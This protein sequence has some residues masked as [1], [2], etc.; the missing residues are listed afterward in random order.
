MI[1][2]QN[3]DKVK[4]NLDKFDK[5]REELIKTSREIVRESKKIIYSIHRNEKVSTTKI[6]TSLKS[7]T[8]LAKKNPKLLYSGSV[9]I[10][11]QEYVEA[12]AFLEFNKSGKIIPYNPEFIDDEFY[13]LG[14]CDL[15]GE[16]VRKAVQEGINNKN[17]AVLNIRKAVDELYYKIL[18][19]DLRN[20]ELRKKSDG[21]KW[22]LKK[23]DE[24]VF[25]LKLR[26]P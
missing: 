21:I 12:I 9:K 13:L 1:N 6:K 4:N 22:D 20:G 8:I 3:F 26:I 2:K 23:L 24:M 5:K 10:A 11:V 16:L 15:S 25:S 18:E 7:L 14:L 19:L 17:K